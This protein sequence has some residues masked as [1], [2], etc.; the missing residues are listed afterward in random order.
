MAISKLTRLKKVAI[1]IAI[2]QGR[3]IGN[4]EGES[5]VRECNIRNSMTEI[6]WDV[7]DLADE[8]QIVV[9]YGFFMDN[10]SYAFMV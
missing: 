8:A 2:P 6:I 4:E 3:L 1:R 10:R 5:S 7:R 9:R